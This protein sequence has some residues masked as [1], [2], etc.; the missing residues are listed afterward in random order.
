MNRST[1]GTSNSNRSEPSVSPWVFWLFSRY[2]TWYLQRHFHTFRLYGAEH[3]PD[4]PE[5]PPIFYL[6]H[7]GWW[8]PLICIQLI[9]QYWTDYTHFTPMD[10]EQLKNFGFFRKIGVFGV[11]LDAPTA[12]RRFLRTCES[13]LDRDNTALWVTPQGRFADARERPMDFRPGLGHL[14]SRLET[15]TLVPLGLTYSFWTDR[16]PEVLMGFGE[17]L[18]IRQYPDRDASEWIDPMETRLASVLDDLLE[19][20]RTRNDDA[21]HVIFGG[22]SGI[23]GVYGTWQR[24][25]RCL[26][27]SGSTEEKENR[28]GGRS[29]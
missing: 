24:F 10:E 3:V 28:T 13:V 8:D 23:G 12:G 1:E 7:P 5:D 11:D 15:G 2:N 26:T 25:R 17:P 29:A 18:R 20:D 16:F 14:A 19:A 9:N 27:G 6:N 22:S 21:F 4:I